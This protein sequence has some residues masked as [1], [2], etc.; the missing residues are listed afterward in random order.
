MPH[1]TN[2]LPNTHGANVAAAGKRADACP[3]PDTGGA[4]ARHGHGSTRG[5][6]GSGSRRVLAINHLGAITEW[7]EGATHQTADRPRS[8]R[9]AARRLYVLHRPQRARR[10]DHRTLRGPLA[11]RR[12]YPRRQTTRRLGAGGMVPAIPWNARSPVCPGRAERW[13]KLGTYCTAWRGRGPTLGE[14]RYL[15]LDATQGSFVV[16]GDTSAR[17]SCGRINAPTLGSRLRKLL[18]P[19]RFTSGG[20]RFLKHALSALV[21]WCLSVSI[22]NN[23]GILSLRRR[24]NKVRAL[25]I[26]SNI[27]NRLWRNEM[28]TKFIVGVCAIMLVLTGLAW[29]SGCSSPPPDERPPRQLM[30]NRQHCFSK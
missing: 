9:R 16:S 30:Q 25:S 18:E 26:C 17:T 6:G 22:F 28:R 14:R 15:P 1:C 20:T 4:K 12:V 11:D 19:L 7:R 24:S 5:L 23:A 29:F 21:S 2:C 8:L 3:C 10:R 27:R 13:S